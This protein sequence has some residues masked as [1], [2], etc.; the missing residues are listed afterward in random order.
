MNTPTRTLRALRALRALLAVPAVAAALCTAG[1]VH[2]VH[3]DTT[4]PGATV[5]MSGKKLG[6]TPLDDRMWWYPFR[7]MEA[8]VVMPGYRTVQLDLSEPVGPWV[9]AGDI[10]R[11]WRWGRLIGVQY[12]GRHE[13]VMIRIHGQSGTWTPEEATGE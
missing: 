12:R 11:P 1:C 3:I 9:L 5:T 10:V 8:R 2:K 6:V 4:P 13:V 7:P